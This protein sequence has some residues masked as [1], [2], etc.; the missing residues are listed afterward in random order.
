VHII[1]KIKTQTQGKKRMNL[2]RYQVA[3]RLIKRSQE[4]PPGGHEDD[5]TVVVDPLMGKEGEDGEGG[6]GREVFVRCL[7]ESPD[8]MIKLIPASFLDFT[9]YCDHHY[10]ESSSESAPPTEDETPLLPEVDIDPELTWTPLDN[11]NS[12]WKDIGLGKLQLV[13]LPEAE[14]K[15]PIQFASLVNDLKK[16]KRDDALIQNGKKGKKQQQSRGKQQ[17]QQQRR[18]NKKKKQEEEEEGEEGEE[19]KIT[20]AATAATVAR[21]GEDGGCGG[22]DAVVVTDDDEEEEET[23]SFPPPVKKIKTDNKKEEEEEKREMYKRFFVTVPLD[24][25]DDNANQGGPILDKEEEEMEK[26]EESTTWAVYSLPGE[27]GATTTTTTPQDRL[28]TSPPKLE[29][30]TAVH[31]GEIIPTIVEEEL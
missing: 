8:K 30:Q 7:D 1:I 27:G 23:S 17:Q 11:N 9:V 10:E 13:Y 28:S 31:V 24:Y 22:G 15:L 26:G 3:T 16:L 6:V 21:G 2:L 4:G 29:R 19:V 20:A 5:M 18:Q 12:D 14:K 25:G